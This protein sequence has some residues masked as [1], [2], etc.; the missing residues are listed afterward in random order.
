MA[1]IVLTEF[2]GFSALR[3]V[4]DCL[5]VMQGLDCLQEG[6]T[7]E[8]INTTKMDMERLICK[9]NSCD[10]VT[11]LMILRRKK[12][13]QPTPT[14]ESIRCDDISDM[15]TRYGIKDI[16]G[17]ARQNCALIRMYMPYLT[18]DQI[19][20]GVEYCFAAPGPFQRQ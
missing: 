10:D 20:T 16:V 11:L 5:P 18:C 7:F 4:Y 3:P 6:E 15:A 17:F 1:C 13:I 8:V 12:A 9:G 2:H 19:N 14:L